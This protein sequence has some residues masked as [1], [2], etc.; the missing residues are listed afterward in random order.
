MPYN[1]LNVGNDAT[2]DLYGPTG[3]VTTTTIVEFNAQQMTNQLESLPLG[4]PPI[5]AEVP[6]GWEGTFKIQ[7]VDATIDSLFAQLESA[8]WSGLNI[9]PS[10]ILETIKDATTGAIHQFRYTGVALKLNTIG[11]RRQDAF[12]DVE[13]SF[14]ASQRVQVS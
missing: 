9:P 11:A 13:V 5:F 12:I 3:Y 1:S 2:L 14:R 10:Q 7:R 8:Y 4:R 6:K